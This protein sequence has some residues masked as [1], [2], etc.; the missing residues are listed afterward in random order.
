LGQKLAQN[1]SLLD[2]TS[3]KRTWKDLALGDYDDYSTSI[4]LTQSPYADKN[5]GIEVEINE[6][7][8]YVGGMAP[9]C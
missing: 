5:K 9:H 1:S 6:H 7:K 2:I 4:S 8:S 3:Q